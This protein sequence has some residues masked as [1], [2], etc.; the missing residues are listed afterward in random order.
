MLSTALKYRLF[1][2]FLIVIVLIVNSLGYAD[3]G[4][5]TNQNKETTEESCELIEQAIVSER[6][7][8]AI[9]RACLSSTQRPS[10]QPLSSKRP[11]FPPQTIVPKYPKTIVH[12]AL[13]I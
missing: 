12:R 1:S 13:L 9:K 4:A 11:L 8:L 10:K 6:K 7:I 5:T 2:H 3:T